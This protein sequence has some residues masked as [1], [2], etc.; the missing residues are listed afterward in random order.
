M[1]RLH[2]TIIANPW[3][4]RRTP[5]MSTTIIGIAVTQIPVVI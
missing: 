5:I 2:S 4:N 1:G 3:A